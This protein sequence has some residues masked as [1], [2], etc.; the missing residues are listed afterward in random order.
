M[1]KLKTKKRGV[2]VVISSLL[3]LAITIVGAVMISN[4]ISASSISSISQTA[5][6]DVASNSLL[7][8]AYDTR[9]GATLSSIS[10]LNNEFD[11]MLCTDTCNSLSRDDIP[12]NGGTDFVV[13]QLR[14]KNL[15]QISIND[16]QVNG[17][18][19][20][21]DGQ[22][23]GVVFNANFDD[24]SGKYPA[25]GKFSI[26]PDSNLVLLEQQSISNI[27]AGDEVR[28]V[29]KLNDNIQSDIGLGDAIY[30]LVN[31]GTDQPAKFIILA[32]DTK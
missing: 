25:A 27:E 30:I 13:L 14:N 10:S 15:F 6:A 2:S 24:S 28:I 21:W 12:A 23:G 7:L 22:T 31:L 9:D 29:I 4:M 32:G 11:D 17:V 8:I 3:I 16:I 26:I 5:R 18:T 20:T 1:R 19:H